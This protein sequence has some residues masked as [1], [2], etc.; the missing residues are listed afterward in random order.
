MRGALDALA[1]RLA[2]ERRAAL[3]PT[4]LERGPRAPPAASD[5][6]AMIEADIA[7]HSAIYAASGNPLIERERAAALACTCAA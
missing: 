6:K 2:A 5:V 3:D 1:A 7:F 4:L